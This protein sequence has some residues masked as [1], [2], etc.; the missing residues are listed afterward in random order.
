MNNDAIAF[1]LKSLLRRIV[2]FFCVSSLILPLYGHQPQLSASEQ[3]SQAPQNVSS[4]PTFSAVAR[5]VVLDIAVVDASGHP[6]KGL[7]QS[8]FAVSEDGAPQTLTSFEE[9]D[10]SASTNA[11]PFSKLPVNTFTN[12][13]ANT[14]NGASTVILFDA[15][16]TSLEAQMYAH[17]QV[18]N[19]IK[20]VAAGTSIAIFQLDD[21][22]HLVQDFSRDPQILL[23]AVN[24]KRGRPHLGFCEN[25]TTDCERRRQ[26]ILLEGMKELGSYLAGIPGRKNL[27]WFIDSIP[28]EIYGD[29]SSNPFKDSFDFVDNLMLTT[30]LLTL[31]RVAVYPVDTRGL[32]APNG[33]ANTHIGLRVAYEDDSLEQIAKATGGKAFSNTNGLKDAIA[34]VVDTGSSYYTVSYTPTNKNWGD[35]FRHIKVELDKHGYGLE[36][37][38]GYRARN[39]ESQEEHHLESVRKKKDS[40]RFIPASAVTPGS[41]PGDLQTAMNFG[42]IPSTELIF[43]ARLAASKDTEKIRKKT[44]PPLNNY[45][46]ADY[47]SKPFHEFNILYDTD[48][49]KISFKQTLDGVRHGQMD[50]VAVLYDDRGEIVNSLISTAKLDLT[51]ATYEHFVQAGFALSQPI[52]IPAKGNY[53]LRLGIHDAI[54]ERVGAMEIPVDEVKLGITSAQAVDPAKVAPTN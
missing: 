34:E 42:S 33:G 51:Q 5:S 24:S 31:S 17:E 41:K 27:I 46:S 16:D 48:I 47:R 22:M 36:Y 49:R 21:G 32:I 35:E 1:S 28:K 39:R 45:L 29:G 52:A 15:L 40:G 12:Y 38:H 7:K 11:S 2:F 4:T 37:R 54:G 18:T 8:D 10:F 53:F 30:D 50:F 3:S 26:A 44:P 6:V 19:Y 14:N 25:R 9:H 23:D 13:V 43:T 20:H